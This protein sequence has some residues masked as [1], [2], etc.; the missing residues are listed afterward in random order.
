V[1]DVKQETYRSSKEKRNHQICKQ[2]DTSEG[3]EE[4][5]RKTLYVRRNQFGFCGRGA[6]QQREDKI[7]RRGD[8]ATPAPEDGES[9]GVSCMSH[10]RVFTLFLVLE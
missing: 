8:I 5:K 4:D 9:F 6:E 1:E 3:N 10:G 7:R 2:Q